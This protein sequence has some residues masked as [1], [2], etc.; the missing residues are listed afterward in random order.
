[1][2]YGDE[3]EKTC[4]LEYGEAEICNSGDRQWEGENRDGRTVSNPRTSRCAQGHQGIPS[5]Y[6]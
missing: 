3:E 6:V 2:A 4:Y 5:G 1:M